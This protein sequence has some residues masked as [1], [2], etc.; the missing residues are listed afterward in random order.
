[1]TVSPH[2]ESTR[3]V[4]SRV[5]AGASFTERLASVKSGTGSGSGDCEHPSAGKTGTTNDHADAWYVGYTRDYAT[6]AAVVANR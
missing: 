6:A 2:F 3:S 4:G 1:M 5:C